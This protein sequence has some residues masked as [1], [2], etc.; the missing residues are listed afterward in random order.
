[1]NFEGRLTSGLQWKII[2][3]EVCHREYIDEHP[4]SDG[5]DW[6]IHSRGGRR[7]RTDSDEE[8]GTV[9]SLEQGETAE[10]D[11][12]LDQ[13]EAE[14]ARILTALGAE[15][16]SP[17]DLFFRIAGG[18]R[19][20]VAKYFKGLGRNGTVRV[21]YAIDVLG[22]GIS[23]RRRAAETEWVDYRVTDERLWTEEI[24]PFLAKL[25]R[26]LDEHERGW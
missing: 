12:I 9:S 19:A 7:Y 18:P 25:S 21:S 8:D 17:L 13:L 22:G 4:L 1:M 24:A 23:Y 5:G 16:K 6:V 11:E 15:R 10:L 3:G 2:D 20:S 14:K 26:A